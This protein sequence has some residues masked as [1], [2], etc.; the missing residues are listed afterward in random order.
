MNRILVEISIGE[1][2]DKISILEIKSEK[3]KDINKLN[4]INNECKNLRDQL[5]LNVK[6]NNEI[7]NLYKSLKEINL[8]L[9]TIE[10]EKRLCERN[11]DFGEKFIKLSRDVHFMNDK[12]AKVKLEINDKTGSKIKE[13]KEYTQY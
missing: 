8:K 11:L 2:L 13:V 9:W 5:D 10:D 4:Y 6:M 3:I 12:R 1:L 7:E